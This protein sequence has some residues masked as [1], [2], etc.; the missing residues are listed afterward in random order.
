MFAEAIK[1]TSN[2]LKKIQPFFKKL[3]TTNHVTEVF[4]TWSGVALSSYDLGVCY[5]SP[6][7]NYTEIALASTKV[8]VGLA[9]ALCST[10]VLIPGPHQASCHIASNTLNMIYGCADYTPIPVV[11]V[12]NSTI[13]K[14]KL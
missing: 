2:G 8:V 11:K 9:S 6:S 10:A 5:V 13:L 7:K 1:I 4:V 12:L 14:G 3:V